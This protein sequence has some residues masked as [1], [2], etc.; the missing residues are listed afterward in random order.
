MGIIIFKNLNN[1]FLWFVQKIGENNEKLCKLLIFYTKKNIS[2]KLK[3]VNDRE[4]KKIRIIVNGKKS[5]LTV[6]YDN[7]LH[8]VMFLN[9]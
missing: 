1:L 5:F 2:A 3:K 7:L 9:I 6:L 4:N 8:K